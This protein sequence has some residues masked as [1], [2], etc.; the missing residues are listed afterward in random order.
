[1][2]LNYRTQGLILKKE[3]RGEADRLFTV[4]TKDFGK[5]RILARSVRKISS[6]LR[7]G[8]EI[9]YLS[10]LEFIQ[11]KRHK[12]LTGAVPIEDFKNL[13][14]DLNRMKVA[15][16]IAEAL[17]DFIKGPEADS[18]IWNLLLKVFRRLDSQKFPPENLKLLYRYFL[19]NF[20]SLMGYGIR[21]EEFKKLK[22]FTRSYL[23]G[24]LGVVK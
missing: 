14:S 9:F 21:P 18:R 5:L 23:S 10:E 6:K 16:Q 3:D 13:R 12:T 24:I 19:F 11:A 4:Y 7:S 1:M 8:A 22:S 17:D 2:F 20:L 15:Y